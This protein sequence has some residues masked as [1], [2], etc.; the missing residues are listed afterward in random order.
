MGDAAIDALSSP[1]C[2][3]LSYRWGTP[4]INIW[5][6]HYYPN[7]GR[8]ITQMGDT[9]Y[10]ADGGCCP[11]PMVSLYDRPEDTK[12]VSKYARLRHLVDTYLDAHKYNSRI[13]RKISWWLLNYEVI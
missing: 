11:H 13:V 3:P 9:H 2:A 4:I 8:I 5:G 6:T 10:R 1:S 12:V 7:G